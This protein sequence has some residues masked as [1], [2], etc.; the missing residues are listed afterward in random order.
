MI[1]HRYRFIFVLLVSLGVAINLYVSHK[2]P[3]IRIS[4]LLQQSKMLIEDVK[5]HDRNNHYQYEANQTLVSQNKE[6][7]DDPIRISNITSDMGMV[8]EAGYG[9]VTT[10][11]NAGGIRTE[12]RPLGTKS[13]TPDDVRRDTKTRTGR[14]TI[15]DNDGEM[16]LYSAFW[17]DRPSVEVPVVRVLAVIQLDPQNQRLGDISCSISCE[18]KGSPRFS[19]VNASRIDTTGKPRYPIIG[20]RGDP[21]ACYNSF[22]VTCHPGACTQNDNNLYVTLLRG[23]ASSFVT[24]TEDDFLPIE[25]PEKAESALNFVL[26]HLPLFGHR[27]QHLEEARIVEWLELQKILGVNKIVVYNESMAQSTAA[28][29][30]HYSDQ[31]FV[32]IRPSPTLKNNGTYTLND[33]LIRQG[34]IFSDCLYRNMYQYRYVVSS[35]MDEVIVPT[36]LSNLL[37]MMSL[38]KRAS[39]GSLGE[40][41]KVS[42]YFFLQSYW[43]A[44]NYFGARV[45]KSQPEYLYFLRHRYRNSNKTRKVRP[46]HITDPMGCIV[47]KQH[48]CLV[49]FDNFEK[50]VVSPDIGRLHHYRAH[51]AKDHDKHFTN[52]TVRDDRLLAF[53]TE[54]GRNVE[55][56]LRLLGFPLNS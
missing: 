56:K 18:I 39:I 24:R 37:D 54:L 12:K 10:G 49:P 47:M 27:F 7:G 36:K 1:S 2:H 48:D 42:C 28:V 45:D 6:L 14:V 29:L 44:E 23:Y 26:C 35:D 34:I 17:D 40:T 21:A 15:S 52:T 9:H 16:F 38:V 32:D 25:F 50:Y 46:K 20:R 4:S 51:P 5:G 53:A 33:S 11:D 31:G 30:L 41:E 8:A 43:P 55:K 13:R 19:I 3:F 22:L